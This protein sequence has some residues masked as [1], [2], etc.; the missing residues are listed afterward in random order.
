MTQHYHN[1]LARRLTTGG[2]YAPPLDQR[3]IDYQRGFFAGA[4][5]I[6]DNPEMAEGELRKALER[7]DSGSG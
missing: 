2:L 4:R 7:R 6:L 5:W 3:E 1:K